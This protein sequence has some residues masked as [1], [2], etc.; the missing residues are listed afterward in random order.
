MF[1]LYTF[2]TIVTE[3]KQLNNN[4]NNQEHTSQTRNSA[5][6]TVTRRTTSTSVQQMS[7]LYYLEV[8]HTASESFIYILVLDN[9]ITLHL[10]RYSSA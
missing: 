2:A 5:E 8:I 9:C 3:A 10:S 6:D 1:V 4:N 7:S